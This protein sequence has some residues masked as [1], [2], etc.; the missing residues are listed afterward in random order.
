MMSGLRFN[1]WYG[2]D[3]LLMGNVINKTEI[4]AMLGRHNKIALQLSGGKDSLI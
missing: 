3:G 1:G 4:E 2:D